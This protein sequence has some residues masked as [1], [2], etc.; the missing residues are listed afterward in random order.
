MSSEIKI[1][2]YPKIF[3][4][5]ERFIENLFNGEV[6]ITEKIDGSMWAFGINKNEEL[7]MRSKGQDLTNLAVPKMFEVAEEQTDRIEKILREKDWKDIYFYS[8]FL[9]A[10]HHNVLNY[11]RVP[12]NNLYLFGVIEGEKFVSDFDKLCWYADQLDIE[13]PR[14]LYKGEVRNVKMLEDLLESDSVLGNVKIEGIVVKNYNQP[15]ILTQNLILPICMGK[16][17]RE[18][19]KEKH[20]K[21]WSKGHTSKGKLE[22]FIS[23]FQAEARWQKAVQHLEEKGELENAP[24]DIGKLMKEVQIDLEEEEKENIKD[25]LYKIFRGDILRTSTRGLPDWYKK[26]LLE[27]GL[28]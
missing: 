23:Q 28:K 5:G 17:V 8:E 19:F 2:S 12:K 26:K 9:S 24:R 4:I 27:K 18:D 20:A 13:R 14:L 3:H 25:G 10:P 16:Y 15:T 21:D 11:E 6:E 22:L 1:K 7:V